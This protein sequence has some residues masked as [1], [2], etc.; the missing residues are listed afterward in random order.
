MSRDFSR[1]NIVA[2]LYGAANTQK[3]FLTYQQRLTVTENEY[4]SCQ[5]LKEVVNTKNVTACAK[6]W[7]VYDVFHMLEIKKRT[8]N[9]GGRPRAFS[10][11]TICQDQLATCCL[12]RHKNNKF[13]MEYC[14]RGLK[15]TDNACLFSSSLLDC[16][17]DCPLYG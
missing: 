3:I 11:I 7:I 1:N 14:P 10:Q 2:R 17:S 8:S 5:Y 15:E 6:L 13:T 16:S 9:L 4:F 12:L